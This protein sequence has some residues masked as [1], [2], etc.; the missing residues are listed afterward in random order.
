M[1]GITTT[2]VIL[3]SD[4]VAREIDVS[5]TIAM[6]PQHAFFE[7]NY[8]QP[9]KTIV[10]FKTHKTASTSLHCIM[11]RYGY[12]NQLSL[13]FSRYNN[14]NGHLRNTIPNPSWFLPPIRNTS[15]SAGKYNILTGHVTY[16]RSLIGSFMEGIPKY[17][18]ILREPAAQIESHMNFFNLRKRVMKDIK[19][20]TKDP[21]KFENGGKAA[22]RNNQISDLGLKRSKTSNEATINATILKLDKEFD[23]VLIAE[24]FDESLLLLKRILRWSFDDIL[25]LVKNQRMHRETITHEFRQ[26]IY[27]W[28]RADVLLYQYF[29]ETLWRRVQQYGPQF[30]DDLVYFG[31][32]PS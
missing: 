11:C 14:I 7:E 9:A 21:F 28:S 27:Q 1:V 19:L 8:T 23:L 26:Q 10:F 6:A 22:S 12:T 4:A 16:Y 13:I 20:F 2:A 29:N 17:I 24:Y 32:L 5:S 15:N 31:A 30:E 18:T 3:Y 25:Y